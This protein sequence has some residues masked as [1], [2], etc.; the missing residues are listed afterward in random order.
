MTVGDF[1]A[2]SAATSSAAARSS[3]RGTT[4]R[5]EPNAWSSAAVAV[6]PV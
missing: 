4:R 2:M 5:T 3:S 1:F 6:A